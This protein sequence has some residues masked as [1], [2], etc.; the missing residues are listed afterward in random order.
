MALHMEP[1]ATKIGFGTGM[2]AAGNFNLA[3]WLPPQR[4][5][6]VRYHHQAGILFGLQGSLVEQ[7]AAHVLN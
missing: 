1:A 6:A 5:N 7:T 4:S 2:P 3:A